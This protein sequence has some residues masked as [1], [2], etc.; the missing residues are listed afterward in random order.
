MPFS[1]EAPESTDGCL[2]YWN[3]ISREIIVKLIQYKHVLSRRRRLEAW[4]IDGADVFD[5]SRSARHVYIHALHLQPRRSV[6]C[7][8]KLWDL[9]NA[10]AHVIFIPGRLG[11]MFAVVARRRPNVSHH[12]LGLCVD[13]F[14]SS[15]NHSRFSLKMHVVKVQRRLCDVWHVYV[16]SMLNWHNTTI[17]NSCLNGVFWCQISDCYSEGM[18]RAFSQHVLHRL[19][20]PQEGPKVGRTY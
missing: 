8:A 20:I 17:C 18:F 19:N 4:N 15:S 7:F 11:N 9:R 14:D 5:C 13:G 16:I 6:V 2:S 1:L 3:D 12:R 10:Q